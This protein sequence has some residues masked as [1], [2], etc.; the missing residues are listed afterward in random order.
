MVFYNRL[1]ILRYGQDGGGGEGGDFQGY[2]SKANQHHLTVNI[3]GG[4]AGADYG[5]Y[6]N[7][8]QEDPG[9]NNGGGYNQSLQGGGGGNGDDLQYPQ[10][11]SA[12]E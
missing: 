1:L 7:S 2:N 8:N 10:S 12:K 9:N 6:N 4:G 11:D 5:Q 3:D